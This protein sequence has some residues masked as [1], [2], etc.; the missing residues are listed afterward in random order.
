[1]TFSYVLVLLTI[2]QGAATKLASSSIATYSYVADY[3]PYI[4]VAIYKI[5]TSNVMVLSSVYSHNTQ[6]ERQLYAHSTCN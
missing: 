5:T 1:M 2:V 6:I 4:Y 3:W